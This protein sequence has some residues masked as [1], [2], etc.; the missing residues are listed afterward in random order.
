M[1]ALCQFDAIDIKFLMIIRREELG[2]WV[3]VAK[4]VM[5]QVIVFDAA[6]NCL[7]D[8]V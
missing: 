1:C 5:I 4:E 2:E 8:S 3:R 7:N 6:N